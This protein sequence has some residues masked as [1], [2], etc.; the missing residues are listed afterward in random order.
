MLKEEEKGDANQEEKRMQAIYELFLSEFEYKY[1]LVLWSRTFRYLVDNTVN[2]SLMDKHIFN[3]HV[4]LNIEAILTMQSELV[5]SM[6]ENFQC[7]NPDA[8]SKFLSL[9]I[10]AEK[11]VSVCNAFIERK[12]VLQSAYIEYANKVPKAT[13]VMDKI[14]KENSLFD[15]E[16]VEVLQR[17]GRLHLGC[18]NFILR[19]MQK[20]TRYPLLFRAIK[21]RG[22]VAEVESLDQ[23]IAAI[24]E[25]NIKVNENVQY[26][27]NYFSMYHLLHSILPDSGNQ[28]TLSFGASQKERQHMREEEVS[29]ILSTEKRPVTIVVL[30]NCVFFLEASRSVMNNPLTLSKRRILYDIMPHCNLKVERLSGS[31]NKIGNIQMKIESGP[32]TYTLEALDWVID[33]LVQSIN[34]CIKAEKEKFIEITVNSFELEISRKGSSMVIT[35]ETGAEECRADTETETGTDTETKPETRADSPIQP[36]SLAGLGTIV[37][38]SES[39]LE[40][41]TPDKRLIMS[42]KETEN[43]MYFK[44]MSMLLYIRNRMLYGVVFGRNDDIDAPTKKITGKIMSAFIGHTTDTQTG[45]VNRFAVAKQIGYLGSEELLVI[46]LEQTG[47]NT[48]SSY[49]HRRMY[50]AGDINDVSFYGKN[51]AIASNDFELINLLD[52]TTQELLDPLDVT[53][54]H[55]VTKAKSKPI[56]SKKI[57]ENIYLI[58]FDDMGFFINR[59]GSRKMAHILFLWFMRVHQVE[60]FGDYIVA[61]GEKQTKLYTTEDG[62]LRGIVD[63]DD[64]K[65][66][67]HSKYLIIYNDTHFYRLLLPNK[68][69]QA[70]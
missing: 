28:R 31:G 4:L 55:Y 63:I 65:V 11:M 14:I 42:T 2:L 66:L 39:G 10:S 25:I 9:N 6:M 26:S 21:K 69:S 49:L 67:R 24:R 59:F 30:D 37:V 46:K 60:M 45:E 40:I 48:F 22:R 32:D 61:L 1:D 12:D 52:L 27:T 57:T 62:I 8:K 33:G 43:V 64:G 13:D 34:E 38:A 7:D 50:I 29:L 36:F 19:P 53:I 17:V 54:N 20:I 56:S 51:I 47:P 58:I 23:A 15:K 70:Q 18:T 41:S 68:N 16:L 44:E 3:V 5:A 35:E